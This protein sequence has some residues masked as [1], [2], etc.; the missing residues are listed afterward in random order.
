MNTLELGVY[1]GV[2]TRAFK[3]QGKT[4]QRGDSVPAKAALGVNLRQRRAL[5]GAGYVTYFNNGSEGSMVV[6]RKSTTEKPQSRKRKGA[7]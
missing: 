5:Q 2:A 4:Y 3:L 6:K 7:K 1:G